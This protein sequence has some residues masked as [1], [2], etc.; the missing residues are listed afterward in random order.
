M[1]R[2]PAVAH[3]GAPR[4][5]PRTPLPG[6]PRPP[7]G[8]PRASPGPPPEHLAASPGPPPRST[9]RPPPD[10]PGLSP[11]PRP[12][13]G[14]SPPRSTSRPPPGFPRPPPGPPRGAS[15]GLPRT[16]PRTPGL[17]RA[18]PTAS[19][20]PSP[21][22]PRGRPRPPPGLPRPPPTGLPPDPSPRSTA[23]P[24]PASP[25]PAAP[26]ARAPR[27][28]PPRPALGP[29][30]R[31][32]ASP[33]AQPQSPGG[34]GAADGPEGRGGARR[35]GGAGPGAARPRD[36][37]CSAPT[38]GP[39]PRTPRTRPR[40]RATAPDPGVSVGLAGRGAA[41]L[42]SPPAA[43]PQR[44]PARELRP[45]LR[46]GRRS[47]A[48]RGWS[49]SKGLRPRLP[50]DRGRGAPGRAPGPRVL[51][52]PDLPVPPQ[53]A[54]PGPARRLQ[55]P[56]R[57]TRAN[58]RS[59]RLRKFPPGARLP[60]PHGRRGPHSPL[61]PPGSRPRSLPGPPPSAP[62]A[63]SA[64]TGD[65][66]ERV[67]GEG[68]GGKVLGRARRGP[69]R[70]LPPPPHPRRAAVPAA[71]GRDCNSACARGRRPSVV[72]RHHRESCALTSRAPGTQVCPLRARADPLTPAGS[73][74]H[75]AA[76]LTSAPPRP[77]WQTSRVDTWGA[78]FA[79]RLRAP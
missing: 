3:C 63:G 16:S 65:S 61:P 51:L 26:D 22:A 6:F 15:R 50:C 34:A 29:T 32:A 48:R 57:G 10:P 18:P 5:R 23:R 69:P 37:R 38:P 44:D 28:P 40:G 20:G 59:T 71:A 53:Q 55:P 4:G 2:R 43:R 21:R 14:P 68:R 8:P 42:C 60:A 58:V 75:L 7:S 35:E 1:T 54:P 70:P 33:R 11:D 46:R 17:P 30:Q 19:H 73:A 66:A 31:T 72:P 27:P 36:S 47:H 56:P 76:E 52:H 12:P 78:N 62:L 64:R 41:R 9:S 45:Q 13:S 67:S 74:A 79:G 39:G 77:H 25:P 49:G 24:P